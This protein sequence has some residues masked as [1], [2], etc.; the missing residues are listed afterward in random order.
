MKK[1]CW[2]LEQGRAP[3][4][5]TD[6]DRRHAEVRR[7]D[8]MKLTLEGLQNLRNALINKVRK[9]KGDNDVVIVGF[10]QNYAIFVHEDMN[11]EHKEGKSAKY[12]EK[13]YVLIYPA[14]PYIVSQALRNGKSVTQGLII[15]GLRIQRAAMKVVPIDT[16]ALRASAFTSKQKMVD[17]VASAAYLRG[18]ATRKATEQRRAKKMAA[19]AAK[20]AAKSASKKGNK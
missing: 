9:A 8:T 5:E 3:G 2:G 17:F 15:A 11:A 14:I 20:R 6:T 18:E 13:A 19:G 16:G 10:T 12:L 4:Y 7:R 1:D